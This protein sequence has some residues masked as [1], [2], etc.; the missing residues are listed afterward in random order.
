MPCLINISKFH[1]NLIILNL[2]KPK[3]CVFA[4]TQ[5]ILHQNAVHLLYYGSIYMPPKD[6]EFNAKKVTL[7]PNYMYLLQLDLHHTKILLCHYN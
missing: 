4:T 7:L 5:F 2:H 1:E 6:S 3:D